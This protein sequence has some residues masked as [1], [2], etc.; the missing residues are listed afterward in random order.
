MGFRDEPGVENLQAGSEARVEG[1]S[2]AR[3][4]SL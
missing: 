2:E 3:T 1:L 4:G